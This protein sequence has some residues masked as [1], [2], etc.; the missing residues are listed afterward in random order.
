[1]RHAFIGSMGTADEPAR[2]IGVLHLAGTSSTILGMQASG[3]ANGMYQA[4]SVDGGVLYT[5][6]TF[7]DGRVSALARSGRELAELGEPRSSGG[8]IPCHLTAHPAGRHL[9]TANYSTGSVAV[10]PIRPDGS[11]AEASQVIGHRGSGPDSPRQ[12]GPHPHMVLCDPR[13]DPDRGDVLVADLGTDTVYRYRLD[14]PSGRLSE[15]GR[16]AMPPGTG[17]RHLAVRGR[18]G[19]VVGELASTV[20]VVDLA[21][22]PPSVLATV[23]TRLRPGSEHSQPSAVTMSPDGRVLYVLNRG[24]DSIATLTVDG[25]EIRLVDEVGSGGAQP[26]DA[27]IDDGFLYVAN[28]HSNAVTV[29]RLDPRTGMPEST[30]HAV[31]FHRPVCITPMAS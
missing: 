24:P 30:G 11:L 14:V 7:A 10:H 13:T 1:M 12:D 27:V 5:T 18:Y 26:W 15:V 6:H 16:I 17:P 2:G 4:P 28:Q 19:Y 23:A 9:L 8:G 20:T 29:F 31:P 25:P 22:S 21:A 3:V